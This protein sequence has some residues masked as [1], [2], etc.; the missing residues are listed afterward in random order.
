MFVAF[1]TFFFFSSFPVHHP[2]YPH[3]QNAATGNFYFITLHNSAKFCVFPSHKIHKSKL[4]F[5]NRFYV[6]FMALCVS[7]MLR[8][9]L[10]GFTCSVKLPCQSLGS[11]S[12]P[13]THT[14]THSLSFSTIW[15]AAPPLCSWGQG[16]KHDAFSLTWLKLKEHDLCVP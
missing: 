11:H 4:F 2:E 3:L 10:I 5:K 14:H 15:W 1:N 16:S 9:Q 7:K 13:L 12:A 8:W 6:N